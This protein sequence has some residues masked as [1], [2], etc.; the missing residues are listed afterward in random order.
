MDDTRL[1][2]DSRL[3]DR[4]EKAQHLIDIQ[5]YDLAERELRAALASDPQQPHLHILLGWALDGQGQLQ[6]AEETG[7]TA[8]RLDPEEVGAMVLLAKLCMDA[9][10]HREAEEWFLQALRL[11]PMEP[12]LYLMY[13][14]LMNKTGHL[15]KAEMLL[16]KC[17]ELDPENEQAHSTLA[18]VLA[19]R[20][21]AVPAQSHGR[22]GVTLD[23][24]SD[25]SHAL[26]G[27]T[28]LATGHPFKA[29]RHL[30]E[31]LRIDPD[32]LDVEEAF[33]DADRATRWIYLPMYYWSLLIDRLPGKQF[34][35]WAGMIALVQILPR[36][37]VSKEIVGIMALAYLAFCIY[38]WVATPLSNAWI[39]ARPPR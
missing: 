13:G 33:L 23:P 7:R 37:G 19:E 28:Y 3:F 20:R 14:I 34:A 1:E 6:E 24:D 18:V 27:Y 4:L 32:D 36:L 15:D 12:H 25:R 38:T 30:R 29:R 16:R 26:L 35:V 5:R 22:Y 9:G 2:F 31:A 11:D 10:R 17:L 8:L 21:Q 39:K